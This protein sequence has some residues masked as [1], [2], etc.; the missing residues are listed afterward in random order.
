MT[1]CGKDTA[2]NTGS[3]QSKQ[4]GF[5][6]FFFSPYENEFLRDVV[7]LIFSPSYIQ[8]VLPA[9]PQLRKAEQ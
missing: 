5:K 6:L 9:S 1:H 2:K 3:F 8:L 7:Q 4:D